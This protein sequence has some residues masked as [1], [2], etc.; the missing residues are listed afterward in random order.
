MDKLPMPRMKLSHAVF[1]IALPATLLY[2]FLLLV[3]A[4]CRTAEAQIPSQQSNANVV[5]HLLT[6]I[7]D[8]VYGNRIA[9]HPSQNVYFLGDVRVSIVDGIA[10]NAHVPLPN[11]APPY[12]QDLRDIGVEADSGHVYV[13][14]NFG[15]SKNR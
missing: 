12:G 6:R 13:L 4:G 7:D 8:K 2:L 11:L 10:V 5:P 1:A 14:D 9:L 15:K 3:L